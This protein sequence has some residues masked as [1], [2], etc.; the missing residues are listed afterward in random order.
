MASKIARRI[1]VAIMERSAATWADLYVMKSAPGA[2]G[3]RTQPRTENGTERCCWMYSRA[4]IAD[5]ATDR[6]EPNIRAFSG[7]RK[8]CA[9]VSATTERSS[10][11]DAMAR[12][13]HSSPTL[14]RAPPRQR[15][16]TEVRNVRA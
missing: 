16:R 8:G 12:R 2:P 9:G 13:R 4:E 15:R 11:V 6:M 7:S 5:T 14:R 10:S 3:P 1:Q